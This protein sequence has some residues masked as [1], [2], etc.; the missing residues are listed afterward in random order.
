MMMALAFLVALST[1]PQG[2]QIIQSDVIFA[3]DVAA[4]VPAFRQVA[5]DF[6][7]GYV[8]E[9]GAPRI[10]QG[11]DLQRIAKNQGVEL[12][13]PVNVCFALRTFVPSPGEIETAMRT[14]LADVHGIAGSRIEISS[15]SQRPVPFGEMIFPRTGLQ[16]P[17]GTQLETL[18]RGLVRHGGEEFPI[19]ARVRIFANTT[20][21]VATTD[22]PIGKPI[23]KDQVRIESCEDFLLDEATARNLDEVV[24]YLPKGLL[25][26]SLPIRKNQLA[27]P[28]DV[29]R[30]ELLDVRVFSGAAHL[31]VQGKAV[32]DGFKGSMI[33]VRNTTSGKEFRARVVGKNQVVVG[34]SIQ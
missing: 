20:R 17:S 15:T 1:P 4:V 2:C 21:V 25:R 27:A 7:L 3:R 23:Q 30:G 22:I 8:P 6:R 12:L 29:A 33:S 16:L 31:V 18:W 34:D 9:S 28:P 32:S 5:G 19:W 11:A 14:T 13:D 24:G 26:A 10:L